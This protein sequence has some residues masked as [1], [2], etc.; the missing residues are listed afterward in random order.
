MGIKVREQI[1]KIL[2]ERNIVS[3]YLNSDDKS[4]GVYTRVNGIQ[5]IFIHPDLCDFERKLKEKWKR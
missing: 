3:L 5:I 2:V 4:N 1:K